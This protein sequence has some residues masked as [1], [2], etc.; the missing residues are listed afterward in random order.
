VID[1]V[2]KNLQLD[3]AA[4]VDAVFAEVT[5]YTRRVTDDRTLVVL[6]C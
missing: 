4:I 3:P 6:R 5:A 1:I 2:R